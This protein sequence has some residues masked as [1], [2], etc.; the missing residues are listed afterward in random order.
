MTSVLVVAGRRSRD[1]AALSAFGIR[2]S[3][4]LIHWF[5]LWNWLLLLL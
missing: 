4:H 5:L 3:R 1:E 2:Q